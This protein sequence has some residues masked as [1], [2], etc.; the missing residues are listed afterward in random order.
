MSFELFAVILQIQQNAVV[1]EMLKK[2]NCC[3]CNKIL[4]CHDV[5]VVQPIPWTFEC[6]NT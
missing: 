2:K 4:K 6:G 3:A 5:F 1:L